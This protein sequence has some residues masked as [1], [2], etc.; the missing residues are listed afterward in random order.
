MISGPE[1]EFV[2]AVVSDFS[3]HS[4]LLKETDVLSTVEHKFTTVVLSDVDYDTIYCAD[5]HIVKSDDELTASPLSIF[6]EMTDLAGLE[7]LLHPACGDLFACLQH[8]HAHNTNSTSAVVV[9]SKQP[10]VWRRYLR[11]AQLLSGPS[12]DALFAPSD[13]VALSEHAQQVYYV[14]PVA[15]G[16]LAAVVGSLGLAMHFKATVAG[17]SATCLMDSCCTNTLMSASYARRVWGSLCGLQWLMVSFM[18][19]LGLARYASNC[20]SFLLI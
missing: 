1:V 4:S 9:L 10:G 8:L 12:G 20:S 14:P 2:T 7:L 16:S 5:N 13:D 19:L 6:L 17:A 18:L 11:D 3:S 15:T